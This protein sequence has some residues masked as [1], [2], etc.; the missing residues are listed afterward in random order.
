MAG[1]K[2]SDS[3]DSVI[4][5]I[6]VTPFVDVVLV[7]L[8][9]FMVTAGLMVNKGLKVNLPEA[10]TA[11]QLGQQTT[12]NI[13]VNQAGDIYLNGKSVSTDELKQQGKQAISDGKKIVA[14]ISAD[15]GV[16]YSMVVGVM[17]ALRTEGISEFALQLQPLEEAKPS[18]PK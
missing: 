7:L 8:V 15:K 14:M 9:V 4:C 2:L 12:F 16:V 17:D 5:E 11:E 18:A 13:L 3:D 6:N 10:A 1:G